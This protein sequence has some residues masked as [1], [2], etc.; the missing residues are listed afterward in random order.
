MAHF[1]CLPVLQ[2]AGFES[3]RESPPKNY[4]ITIII[5]FSSSHKSRDPL[6]HGF[7]RIAAAHHRYGQDMLY[8]GRELYAVKGNWAFD[9]YCWRYPLTS[10]VLSVGRSWND[11]DGT[12]RLLLPNRKLTTTI[13]PV[14]NGGKRSRSKIIKTFNR[15]VG[16]FSVRNIVVGGE[17]EE[18]N[19]IFIYVV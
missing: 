13:V 2:M 15:M 10:F 1:L 7:F 5:I 14:A 8:W 11:D 16:S 9:I 3:I 19:I 4:Y 17:Q 18:M 6:F 12:C